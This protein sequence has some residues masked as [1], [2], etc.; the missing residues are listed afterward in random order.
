VNLEKL[1]SFKYYFAHAESFVKKRQILIL[2]NGKCLLDLLQISSHGGRLNSLSE[3]SHV[4]SAHC[5]LQAAQQTLE[6]R[7]LILAPNTMFDTAS[8]FTHISGFLYLHCLRCLASDTRIQS[9][10]GNMGGNGITIAIIEFSFTL[11]TKLL[12]SLEPLLS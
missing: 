3:S 9:L 11:N 2:Y 8:Y 12:S 10:C 5:L 6:L 1:I 4:N 7:I